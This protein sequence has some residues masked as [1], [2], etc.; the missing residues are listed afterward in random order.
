MKITVFYDGVCPLCLRE[1][2]RWRE[3]PFTCEVEW[4]DITGQDEQLREKGIDPASA[5]L[6]LHT[7]TD[8]GQIRTSIDSYGLLLSQLKRWRW[9]G[10]LMLL[11]VIRPMLKW[12]YDWMTRVRLKREG[13]FPGSC[14]SQC[15]RR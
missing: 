3:A 11:P 6:E 7:M 12:A 10:Q 14:N 9:L 15:D 4:L 1:V 8:D 13:R 5:L 2:A